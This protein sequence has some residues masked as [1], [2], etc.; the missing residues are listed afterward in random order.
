VA[1]KNY[2]KHYSMD[3][4]VLILSLS[5]SSKDLDSVRRVLR[6]FEDFQV[7]RRRQAVIA[8]GGGVLL[9]VVGVAASLYRR[10]VAY[11]RVPTTLLSIVDAGVGAKVGVNFEGH[12]N[13]LGSFYPAQHTFVDRTF[14]RT[15]DSRQL[16]SGLAEV[17][18]IAIVRDLELFEILEQH[19]PKL[20][21]QKF[22]A[23]DE[24]LHVIRRAIRGMLAELAPNLWEQE[25]QR[26]VDFGHTFGPTIEMAALPRI[27]HGE[28]VALDMSLSCVLASQ[29]GLLA[30]FELDRILDLMRALRLPVVDSSL[31]PCILQNA[32]T[33]A[34]I[35][36]GGSLRFPLPTRIG[37]V[38]FFDDINFTEISSAHSA[39]LLRS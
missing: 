24:G 14:L 7:P 29:R 12:K 11:V 35:H 37:A 39:L 1:I 30:S 25:L 27:L 19:G 3:V 8:V 33:D 20:L 34:A 38:A 23:S 21:E 4:H 16:S 10:G 26:P 17:L 5:E 28:A 13:R 9:D 31:D 18:K 15:V 2:F 36:R 32:V 6:A 22:Q